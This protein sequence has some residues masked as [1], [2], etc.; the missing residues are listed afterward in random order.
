MIAIIIATISVNENDTGIKS[1][2]KQCQNERN[3]ASKPTKAR[4]ISAVLA[5]RK[6]TPEATK[7][8]NTKGQLSFSSL[9]KILGC[10]FLASRKYMNPGMTRR[11]S[12]FK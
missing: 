5:N 4:A 7:T 12:Q 1:G 2:I 11:A 10:Q 9:R 8:N 3:G 6:N